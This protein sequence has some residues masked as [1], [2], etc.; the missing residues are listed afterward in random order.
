MCGHGVIALATAIIEHGLIT[1]HSPGEVRFDTPAGRVIARAERDGGSVRSVTFENVPAFVQDR[2]AISVAGRPVDYTIA[3]GGAFYAYVDA[4]SLGLKLDSDH[5]GELV[6]A[7]AAVKQA[8]VAAVPMRHPDGDEELEFLYGVIFNA[9]GRSGGDV[10]SACIFADGEL[11]RSPTGTGVSGKAAIDYFNGAIGLQEKLVV[12]SVIDT[13]FSVRCIAETRLGSVPA[14]VTEVSGRA[15]QT[16]EHRFV[17]H[18]EDPLPEGFL[19][20]RTAWI[21]NGRC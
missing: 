1:L 2:G 14:V 7:G 19:V 3:F 20:G 18:G 12:E 11:D 9:P 15:F 13:R 21:H 8:V 4:A 17:V 5:A 6:E 10:R 16:G